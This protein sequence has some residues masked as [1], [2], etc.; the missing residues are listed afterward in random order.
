MMKVC[1]TKKL[2]LEFHIAFSK[3]KID[4][5]QFYKQ[6]YNDQISNQ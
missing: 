1:Q 6:E 4:P 5:R 2:S 3:H